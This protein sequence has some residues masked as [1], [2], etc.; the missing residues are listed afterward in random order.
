MTV[1]TR[2]ETG[3][4]AAAAR[5]APSVHNTQPWVLEFHDDDAHGMSL[6]QRFDRALPRHDPLGRDR[7]MSCGAALQNVLLAMRILGWDPEF[8]LFPNG[9]RRDEVARVTARRRRA[10][11][12]VD[13]ARYLAI[14]LRRSYRRPFAAM[15]VDAAQRHRLVSAPAIDG[16]Q[17][18]PVLGDDET[19][20]LAK[21]FSHAALVLRADRGYQRE[22]AAWTP[23]P[24][25]GLVPAGAATLPWA[26]LVRRSTAV[27]DVATL[28]D[29]LR[30]ECLLLIE[31]PDD[32]QRDHVRA[33]MAAQ[34]TWLTATDAGLVGSVLTQPIQLS[35][36]RSGLIEQLYLAGFP[37]A[38][39]R[40]GYPTDPDV[41][42]DKENL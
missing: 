38:L 37:Q 33:G 34:A 3:V 17:L 42:H 21:L 19:A 41:N 6:F 13:L 25:A 22:L 23:G 16:V 1:W 9:S 32:G 24:G 12:D 26:G 31:T 28:A 14:S 20:A 11:S 27:P 5:L 36:V 18:R 35:E 40:L 7:L 30:C 39:L 29:R 4:V 2:G 8:D 15:L 10:P